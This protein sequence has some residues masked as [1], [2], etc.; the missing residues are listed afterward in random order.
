MNQYIHI[1]KIKSNF[2]FLKRNLKRKKGLEKNDKD[3]IRRNI[4]DI[5]ENKNKGGN[6]LET[7][8]KRKLKPIIIIILV[9]LILSGI[10]F[11][12]YKYL[13]PKPNTENTPSNVA[14]V[15]NKIEGYDY[16]LDDRDTLLFQEIFK[17]LKE[18]LESEEIN[19]DSY[20]EDL[21][22]LFIIDL[23]TLDNKINKYDI[24]G[25]D[26]VYENAK[27]SFR[28]KILD[29]IYK[30]VEDNSYKTRTQTLPIVESVT[31]DSIEPSSYEIEEKKYN[32]YLI[33]ISWQY[34]EDLGYDQKA[35]I[36]MIEEDNKLNIVTYKPIK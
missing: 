30:T 8:K 2:N 13:F 4:R 35:S 21:S 9:L 19:M 22:K 15:T 3:L 23:F 28:A 1:Q 20:V 33:R 32:A 36:T 31:I 7:K 18:N 12:V 25:L 10:S 24:G 27:E 16:T 34:T 11:A 29:T 17:N 14:K 26:Y 6:G 5:I